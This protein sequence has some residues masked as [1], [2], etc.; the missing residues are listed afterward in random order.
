MLIRMNILGGH[1][2][3]RWEE[4]WT[5]L[6][7]SCTSLS[8]ASSFIIPSAGYIR[9]DHS[10]GSLICPPL[11]PPPDQNKCDIH[12]GIC[13]G[14]GNKSSVGEEVTYG[15]LGGPQCCVVGD[16]GEPDKQPYVSYMVSSSL[17]GGPSIPGEKTMSETILKCDWYTVVV[18][19]RRNLPNMN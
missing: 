11:A 4:F 5:E 6:G 8:S 19:D 17:M 10:S 15:S 2:M 14:S 13:S 16:G 12:G 18:G 9:L 7:D 1:T 3:Y